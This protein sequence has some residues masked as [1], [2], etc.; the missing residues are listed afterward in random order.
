MNISRTFIVR[1]V[2][3]T[4][5]TL[6]IVLLGMVAFFILPVSSLP[7]IDFPVISIQAA[8]PGANPE[9]MAADVATP[10]E[11][12]LGRIAAINEITSQ[13]TLGNTR[14][15][16]Q[17]DLERNING[18]AR[19]VQ[20]AINAARTLLPTLPTNPIY[21][22]FNPAEAPVLIMSLTSKTMDQGQLYDIASSILSQKISQ[23]DGVGQV[24]VVGSSLPAVRID[25]NPQALAMQGISMETVRIA[26]AQ[27]NPNRPKGTVES[28]LTRWQIQANDQS[29]HA[30]D[31]RTLIIAWKNG[32]PIRLQDVATITDSVQD[33][34]NLGLSNGI[35][36]VI[37]L[38]TRQPGANVIETVDRVLRL[39]PVLQAEIPAQ[40]KLE[41]VIDRTP[42]IRASL[43]EVERTLVLSTALVI[44]VVFLFL[45]SLRATMIP[46]IV[47]PTSLIGTFAVM[48]LM[49]Y[50]ID[51]LS[52]MALTVATGFVVDDAIVVLENI[53]RHLEAGVPPVEAA[54][55]GAREVGFTVVSIS[56]SLI[57]VFLPI[58]AMG[59]LVG[60][61][62]HE[63]AVVISAAILVSL[64]VSLTTTPMI[65]A[66][67][68]KSSASRTVHPTSE[69]LINHTQG[70]NGFLMRAYSKGLHWSLEH[71]RI[72]LLVLGLVIGLNFYLY[73][74][75]PK[76]FFPQQDTGR[77]IGQIQAD[78]SISFQAMRE[79][80]TRYMAIIK[81]DPAVN[82]VIGFTGGAQRNGGTIFVALKSK[83]QRDVSVDAVI[84][85]LRKPLGQVAGASLFLQSVQ[86]VRV[87]G[88][89]G[90]AQYQY[91][92]QGESI[93]ELSQWTPKIL[94]AL[95]QEPKVA[96]VSADQ[97]DQGISNS[98]IIHRDL[99]SRL[100][101]NPQ[102]LDATLSDLYGQ[103]QISVIYEPLNQYQVVMEANQD[104]L[105]SP[106]NLDRTYVMTAAGTSIP[107]SNFVTRSTT[108]SSLGINHQGQFASATFSFNL[109]N[110]VVL[111][112]ATQ[113]IN[114]VMQ[115]IGVPSSI[116][117]GFQ[118]TAKIFQDSLSSQPLLIVSAILAIYL[119]LGILYE[120]LIH[121][122]TILSTLPSA[123]VG[124]LLAL[125]ATKM[126]FS[127]IALIGVILLI[128]IVKK[129]A[130][131]MIDFALV[132][133]RDHQSSAQEAI[134]EAA[135]MR[136]R[137]IMMT[138][139]AAMLGAIPL[140][141][142]FGEG[143]ELRQPLGVAIIGG[144]LIS[145][146][147]TLFT[148]PVVYIYLDR[149]RRTA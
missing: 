45:R 25:V 17:F 62:F 94:A 107:L 59:G 75:V 10:L 5:L 146:L 39:Q 46:L 12:S 38:I 35:P 110:G 113:A 116:I 132:W 37:L 99:A 125:L 30:I 136:F 32:A 149:L 91:T 102:I 118:G 101:V 16:V 55:R 40:A 131:M 6:G 97:Q 66:R 20:A 36:A 96:D 54:L 8:L 90:N 44:L 73:S 24:Q 123:G 67:I 117:G 63:F 27:S 64:V 34:R 88:R 77:L 105:I 121:P 111:G 72:I 147:L 115:R 78:Q 47:V 140:A 82:N 22:K 9:N 28:D 95:Q 70:F 127:L 7:K 84:A 33:I 19:D 139:A 129:N 48:Y 124:A 15:N 148:T 53:Q 85:R 56:V 58:L 13:S 11:R 83:E 98:L 114:E 60:R 120:S 80:L 93:R 21:R 23:I 61:L 1:P 89:Q 108:A 112:E 86:D 130:I 29:K 49:D 26:I 143:S 51:N 2:A 138:T 87:G 79:K 18:A 43:R 69:D 128:G 50:S 137:P 4:L 119:V 109:P 81:T 14:I 31:F 133:Q 42:S 145:Q 65:C 126:E 142:G 52:L 92:L 76:G 122:L 141:I 135:I 144:L 71:R 100:G 3:T 134:T 103:R 68:L 57:V 104:Q 74:I 41:A 106:T